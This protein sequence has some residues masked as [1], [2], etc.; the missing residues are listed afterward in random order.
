V[1]TAPEQKAKLALLTKRSKARVALF[2][3]ITRSQTNVA[4]EIKKT[5]N[6]LSTDVAFV[7][8]KIKAGLRFK[9][10]LRTQIAQ[11]RFHDKSYE[12]D[13][14]IRWH[15]CNIAQTNRTKAISQ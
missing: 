5:S 11:R 14:T 9:N 10:N 6:R 3:L 15:T 1:N 12:G 7:I 8:L 2:G 4:T 13:L